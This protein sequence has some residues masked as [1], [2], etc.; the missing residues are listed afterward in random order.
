[1]HIVVNQETL[2]IF[3][4]DNQTQAMRWATEMTDARGEGS[5]LVTTTAKPF[6]VFWKYSQYLKKAAQPKPGFVTP[7]GCCIHKPSGRGY[8]FRRDYCALL[9]VEDMPI[10]DKY[11]EF[12]PRH[13]T[14][15]CPDWCQKIPVSE[16][17]TFWMY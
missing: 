8:F 13:R 16:F 2:E 9:S 17:S 7:Y 10:P 6:E 4:F 3:E 12:E 11:V 1:M 5:F 15:W 14:A